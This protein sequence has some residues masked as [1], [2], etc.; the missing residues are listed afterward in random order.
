MSKDENEA[1]WKV[2]RTIETAEYIHLMNG[3]VLNLINNFN[4]MYK[5]K[6]Y[7]DVLNAGYNERLKEF[8]N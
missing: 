2:L 3:T 1:F 7:L 8:N 5:C 4:N 6:Q